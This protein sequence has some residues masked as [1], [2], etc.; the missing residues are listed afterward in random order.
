[1]KLEYNYIIRHESTNDWL[2]LRNTGPGFAGMGG[3]GTNHTLPVS[4]SFAVIVLLCHVYHRHA[5]ILTK[6][7]YG[8]IFKETQRTIA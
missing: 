2:L 6:S 1:M 7:R 4:V 3:G 5:V 8:C